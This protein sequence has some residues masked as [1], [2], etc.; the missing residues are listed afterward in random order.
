M[1]LA[2]WTEALI[3][4]GLVSKAAQLWALKNNPEIFILENE[5]PKTRRGV[6]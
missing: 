6:N 4:V 3:N 1:K 2:K 5:H